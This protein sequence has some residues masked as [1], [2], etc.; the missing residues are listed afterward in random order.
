MSHGD[1]LSADSLIL[2]LHRDVQGYA[3]VVNSSIASAH[4]GV[5]PHP[6]SGGALY[7]LTADL[8][9]IH[10]AVLPLCEDG[11]AF[12][13]VPLLRTMID[14]L[15]NA[16]VITEQNPEAEYRGFKYTHFFLKAQLKETRLP[17]EFRAGLRMQL[18]NGIA[19]LPTGQQQKARYFIFRERLWSYW[20]CPEYRRPNE[21]LNRLL[22]EE[23]Q[24]VYDMFS[25][26]S[27]GGYLGLSVLKDE[28]DLKHPNQRADA[29]SQNLALAGSARLLLETMNIRDHFENGGAN[30]R[31]YEGLLGQLAIVGEKWPM[32]VRSTE[33]E[34]NR[35]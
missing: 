22:S 31:V 33:H 15:M 5:S 4:G 21:I 7:A 6:L 32:K 19:Q 24:F 29:K 35:Q 13:T 9:G 1:F 14:F 17:A 34:T 11:W 3:K 8:F 26:G 23:I 12:A 27:H 30:Q 10:R 18:E 25:G 20:Y 16:A 28:P 2:Q